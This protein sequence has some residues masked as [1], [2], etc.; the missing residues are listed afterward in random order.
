M[1]APGGGTFADF[2]FGGLSINASG[3]VASLRALVGGTNSACRGTGT[4]LSSIVRQGDAVPGGGAFGQIRCRRFPSRPWG[5]R[6]RWRSSAY[7]ASDAVPSAS[8]TFACRKA[9]V[10]LT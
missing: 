8:R 5:S 10:P 1:P 9:G 6:S 7:I 4:I 3:H 2:P